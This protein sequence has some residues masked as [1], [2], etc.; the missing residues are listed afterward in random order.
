[1]ETPVQHAAERLF[2]NNVMATQAALDG[3]G[4]A[5]GQLP[6]VS[7]ALMAGRLVAPFPVAARTNESWFLEYRPV[8]QEEP[9]LQ[10]FRS[11]LHDEAERQRQSSMASPANADTISLYGFG[12]RRAR[13][14]A[15]LGIQRSRRPCKGRGQTGHFRARPL[16]A[17]RFRPPH[18]PAA[19]GI[20]LPAPRIPVPGRGA[21]G[22]DPRPQACVAGLRRKR[23][24]RRPY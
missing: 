23:N 6:F 3:V 13:I 21:G 10:A 1:M 20:S 12:Q 17:A 7:D 24:L 9:A 18:D 5:I 8:R 4:V 19:L 22:H 16:T 11:W 2:E 14:A 15:L